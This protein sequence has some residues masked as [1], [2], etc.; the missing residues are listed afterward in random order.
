MTNLEQLDQIYEAKRQ[1]GLVDVKFVY[2]DSASGATAE[3]LAGELL[4]LERAIA[5]GNYTPLD[6]GD[7]SLVA[8]EDE[9]CILC[10]TLNS[11]EGE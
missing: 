8:C 9:G 6:F 1:A 10:G 4:A 2:A 11:T 7:Y 5:A 3:E